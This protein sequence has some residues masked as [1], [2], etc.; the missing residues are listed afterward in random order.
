MTLATEA[1]VIEVNAS[2]TTCAFDNLRQVMRDVF[3]QLEAKGLKPT[4]AKAGRWVL[5]GYEMLS[6]QNDPPVT[7]FKGIPVTLAPEIDRERMEF[8]CGDR[9]VGVVKGIS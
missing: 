4:A 6:E 2:R 8:W 3:Y 9:L 7:T 5:V 1:A